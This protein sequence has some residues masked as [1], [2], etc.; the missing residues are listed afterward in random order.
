MEMTEYYWSINEYCK[1]LP[2]DRKTYTS[3]LPLEHILS[4]ITMIVCKIHI[5]TAEQN[6]VPYCESLHMNYTTT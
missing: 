6:M 3:L 1:S 5:L 4:K 2:S